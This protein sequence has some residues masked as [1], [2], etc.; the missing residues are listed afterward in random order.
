MHPAVRIALRHLLVEDAAAGGHPLHV[1]CAEAPA[2][3]E[4]VPVLDRA[5]EHVGDR[6]DAAVRVPREPGEVFV[7]VVVAEVVEEQKRVVFRG[8]AEP[9]RTPQFDA[10]A[11]ESGL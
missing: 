11:F 2:I 8:V 3:A 9:E 1:A 5:G 10:C 4:A 7:G 6:L